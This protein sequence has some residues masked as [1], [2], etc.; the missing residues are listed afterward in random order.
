M[1]MYDRFFILVIPWRYRSTS[2]F[3]RVDV[4]WVIFPE[5][6]AVL[7]SEEEDRFDTEV[8]GLLHGCNFIEC[9]DESWEL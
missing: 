8:E 9:E 3:D 7:I 5:E 4:L 1:D 2:P 6:D